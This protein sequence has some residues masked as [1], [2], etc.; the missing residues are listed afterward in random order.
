[1]NKTLPDIIQIKPL[2]NFQLFLEY[3]DGV[4]G[5]ADLSHLKG[6]GVFKWWDNYDN[7]KKVSFD[8][9]GGLVW[10]ENV[11]VDAFNCYLKITNKTFEEYAGS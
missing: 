3:S 1:M 11:D 6:K 7:F 4:K 5:I 10:N 8:G 2:E 9:C